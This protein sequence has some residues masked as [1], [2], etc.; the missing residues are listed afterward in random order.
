MNDL[1]SGAPEMSEESRLQ[2]EKE[3]QEQEE[4]LRQTQQEQPTQRAPKPQ[5]T[6]PAAAE[7]SP[8]PVEPVEPVQPEP[9]VQPEE[10]EEEDNSFYGLTPGFQEDEIDPEAGQIAAEALLAL[11]TGAVDFVVDTFNLVPGVD[12]PK[13]PEFENEVAQTVR[14]MGSVVLPTVGL[15]A[16]GVGIAGAGAKLSKLKFLA[17]PMVARLGNIGLSAGA[18]AFVD[19]TVEINQKDDNVAGVLKKNWPRFYGWIPEDLATL[20]S[21]T[22]DLKRTKNV[23]EGTYLGIG[24]DVLLG[25]IKLAGKYF[26]L[27]SKY[28]PE[29]EKGGAILKKYQTPSDPED[30]VNFATAARLD[31]MDETG[32]YNF[33]KSVEIKGSVEEALK[34]P[35]PFV[36]DLWG[37][38]EMGIRSVDGDINLAAMDSYR[39]RNNVDSI[40]G[41]VGSIATDPFIKKGLDLTQDQTKQFV[42]LKNQLKDVKIGMKDSAGTYHSAKQIAEDGELL[43]EQVHM[44]PIREMKAMLEKELTE[45]SEELGVTTL[46]S[47]G[48]EAAR[49]LMKKYMDDLVDMDQMKAE[50]YL[51]TSMAGQVSDMSQGLRLVEGS[52]AVER[53]EEQIIDRLEYLMAMRGRSAY[54][55]GRALNMT[56]MWNRLTSDPTKLNA[57]QYSQRVQRLLKEET[58]ETLRAIEAIRYDASLTAATLRE[59]KEENPEMIAPLLMAYEFTDGNVDTVAKLNRFLKA[60]TGTIRKAFIDK[61]PEIPSVILQGFWSNVYNATLSAFT[62]PLKAG[63]SNVAGLIEKPIGAFIGGV[64]YGEGQMLRRAWYQYSLNLEVLQDSFAYMNQVFKRSATEPDV[65]GLARENYFTKNEKQIE[66]LEAVANA[67]AEQG[68]DGPMVAVQQIK[69]MN[70]LAQHPWL[71]FGNRAMQAMDGFTQAMIGHAEARGRAFDKLTNNGAKAFDAEAAEALYKKVYKDMFDETGL[72]KDEAVR[73]TAGEI[74]LNLDNAF[75]DALYNLIKR[76]TILKPFMLFT[77]TPLN[78]LRLWTTYSPHALF[79]RELNAFNLKPGV[80]PDED[81][82]RL[83]LAR[84]IDMK[85][86]TPEAMYHKYNEIRGDLL[87]RSALGTL[88]VSGAIGLILTDRITG[89]GHYNKQVQATRRDTGW[90]PRSIR[91]PGGEWVSYDNLGPITNWLALVADIGD[92]FDVLSPN[93]IGEQL[94]KMGFILAASITDKTYLAGVEPFLDVLRGDV[95]AANRWSGSFITSATLPGSSLMAEIGRL[96]DPGLRE[97]ETTMLDIA[98][99]RLPVLKTQL[100]KKYDWIDGGEVGMPD[101]FL[102]RV[103]NTYMPWKV[104]GKISDEKK[105]LQEIEY[106]AR[107]I[108]STDG[109]GVKYTPAERSEIMRIM[110]EKGYFLDGIREVMNTY[111][112]KEFRKEYMEAVNNGLQVKPGKFGLLHGALDK[113]LRYVITMAAAQVSNFDQSLRKANVQNAVQR[114]T[115]A[116]QHKRA[117]QLLEDMKQF[118]K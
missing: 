67:R 7:P 81:I 26:G 104:N 99:N 13:I 45:K 103:W 68:L 55:R 108:L 31:A 58:N 38:E 85:D 47:T 6:A 91:L 93:D 65:G 78:D 28:I 80:I 12:L 111:T 95:G 83:L 41:R 36:H 11:P 34:D 1:F 5:A 72:I 61:T 57:K 16:S 92:N 88:A 107:P 39:V 102:A 14:E 115:Q 110:G 63:F 75:N 96:M 97:V 101:T 74:A 43:A 86:M 118:S 66:I 17:D 24:T 29:S 62:T 94:R 59:L 112:A 89:N 37:P 20:D 53:V 60:S 50:A 114:L 42:E 19:Y 15:A 35:I 79:Y 27:G 30:A 77:K 98:R 90:K 54:V 22:P 87:G 106:D 84:K 56:N 4:R 51:A 8:Q 76:A 23:V 40:Y 109:R 117:L 9:P 71:R 21:D 82:E 100:P 113:K 49:K 69:A 64:R 46:S 116:G 25:G 33:D 48:M 105:F 3:L 2:L 70:D 52:A 44:M 73:Y 32:K 18:G 10:T